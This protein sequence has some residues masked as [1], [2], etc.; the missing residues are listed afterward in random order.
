[1]VQQGRRSPFAMKLFP[2]KTTPVTGLEIE[3]D[4]VA[5]TEVRVNGAAEL[6]ASGIS[7]LK[8]GVFADGEVVDA[9]AL[10]EALKELFAREKLSKEVRIGVSNQ[11]LA[12]RILRLPLIEDSDELETAIRFQ[13]Q[14]ELPMPLDQAVLDYQVMQR[15]A[16]EDG[17]RQ[18]DVAVVAARRDMVAGFV[19][20]ARSAGLKPVGIDLTAFG[21]I[22]ALGSGHDAD[23]TILYC[24]LGDLA[25]LAVARG[26]VCSFT[27]VAPFGL[28]GIARSL[29]DRKGLS[30]DHARQWISHVGLEPA[31]EEVEGDPEIVT[32][33][34]EVLEMGASKLVDELRLSLD[35]YS[36]REGAPPVEEIVFCGP[37]TAVAGM[38]EIL[39]E[40]IGLSFSAA[41]PP[42]LGHLDDA[43]AARLTAAFGLALEA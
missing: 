22:R 11:R 42:Q 35:F 30:L 40:G 15:G 20:A 9:A 12:M 41:R 39:G 25:N 31:V 21:V 36:S 34:R 17:S 7:P 32:V 4:S 1:M 2:T 24:N 3:A 13:A 37:G 19:E 14:D 27:R 8:P 5:A 23:R 33:A 26:T 43:S 16:A 6:G 28:E 29:A 38:A 18:M 10:G